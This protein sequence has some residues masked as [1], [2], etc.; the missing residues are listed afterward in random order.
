[1]TDTQQ[2]Y[3]D[4]NKH[5][6]NYPADKICRCGHP[7]YRHFDTYDNMENIGC[8]YCPCYEFIPLADGEQP[9]DIHK[10]AKQLINDTSFDQPEAGFELEDIEDAR[11]I[12]KA[13]GKH[14]S[15]ISNDEKMTKDEGREFRSAIAGALLAMQDHIVV[16]PALEDLK[17]N[18]IPGSFDNLNITKEEIENAADE[19]GFRVPYDGSNNFYN[20]D[21][22]KGFLAGVKFIKKRFIK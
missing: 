12:V 10:E 22:V 6:P 17:E 16:T 14:W 4:G 21:A 3:L 1:M 7:Y 19:Y 5:N 11:I 15:I 18:K 9:V 13:K 8:K 20:D 2:P